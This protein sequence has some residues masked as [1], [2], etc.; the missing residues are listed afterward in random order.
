MSDK[1]RVSGIAIREGVSRNGIM[2]LSEELEKFAPTLTS[3]PILKDHVYTTES[4]IGLV[5]DSSFSNG[6]VFYEGWL[7]ED[8]TNILEKIRDGR[9]K[10]V[11]VGAVAG[12]LVKES[13]DSD[14]MIAKD[15]VAM[16]LSLTPTPGVVGTSLTSYMENMKSGNKK[17]LMVSEN[18]NAIRIVKEDNQGGAIMADL[19]EMEKTLEA[20]EQEILKLK[21]ELKDKEIAE[22]K[23]QLKEEEVSP[24]E[25]PAEEPKEEEVPAKPVEDE[26][27]G[28]VEE[29]AAEEKTEEK[30]TVEKIDGR[31]ASI[32]SDL[33]KRSD[34]S[35]Y[36]RD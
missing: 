17:K 20:K 2:Y 26:T 30:Y 12:R 13:E 21:E 9:I 28:K 25:A 10:E 24:V 29:P 6:E 7:K 3:R 33:S 22:L 32:Y 16:E 5:D 27:E 8:G 4:A 31:M 23:A 14:V 1:Q 19:K 11:S 18:I 36:R 35:R 15:M 34:L